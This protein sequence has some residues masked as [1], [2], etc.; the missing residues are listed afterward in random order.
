M[1]SVLR[2][3]C[4]NAASCLMAFRWSLRS[5]VWRA[6]AWLRA[7]HAA[8]AAPECSELPDGLS[9]ELEELRVEGPRLDSVCRAASQLTNLTCLKCI[10]RDE[11]KQVR[12]GGLPAAWSL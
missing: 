7:E 12:S 10:W 4:P 6:R 1:L 2:L 3:L 11:G 9:L 5:S 8:P